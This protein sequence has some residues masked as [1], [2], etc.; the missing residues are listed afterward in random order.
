[1]RVHG[2]G[3]GECESAGG[4]GNVRERECMGGRV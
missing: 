4:G 3:G 2:G 1:M